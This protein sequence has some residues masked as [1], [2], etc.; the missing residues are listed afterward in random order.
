MSNA[1]YNIYEQINVYV[2]GENE[3]IKDKFLICI[4]IIDVSSF[5]FSYLNN[6][7]SFCFVFISKNRFC[8]SFLYGFL[9]VWIFQ[10]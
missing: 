8:L 9:Y 4:N 5:K 3:L 2:P 7:I 6:Q 1:F 10:H